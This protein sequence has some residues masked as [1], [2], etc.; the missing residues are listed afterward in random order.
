[1]PLSKQVSVVAGAHWREREKKMASSSACCGT[2]RK[3]I[4]LVVETGDRAGT[5]FRRIEVKPQASLAKNFAMAEPEGLCAEGIRRFPR[6]GV[7][8]A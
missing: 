8:R 2:T 5:T 6:L 1:M 4:P 3:M 7:C